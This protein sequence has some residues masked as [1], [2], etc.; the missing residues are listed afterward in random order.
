[1]K[2]IFFCFVFSAF[3]IISYAQS[4]GGFLDFYLGQ[5]MSE[6]RSITN[7][8]YS[9]VSWESNKCVIKN[10]VLAGEQFGGLYI[11]FQNG[12]IYKAE[13]I[14]NSA[15]VG[16]YSLISNY[17]KSQVELHKQVIGR[18]YSAYT[19][20]YGKESVMTDQSIIW[21]S[22]NGN[23]VTIALEIDTTDFG[24]GDYGGG[25]CTRVTYSSSSYGNY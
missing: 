8:K 12:Y 7:S 25:V 21:R 9:S 3:A 2:K 4:I 14:N 19:S 15:L 20:K 17:V 10:V 18:L 5:S 13:F 11:T 23:S 16:S 24:F 22:P 6:V 1:M